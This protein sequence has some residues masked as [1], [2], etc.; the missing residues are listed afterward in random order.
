MKKPYSSREGAKLYK[1]TYKL[2]PSP[3]A[4]THAQ[5][6]RVRS[7]SSARCLSRTTVK[8]AELERKIIFGR[9]LPLSLDHIFFLITHLVVQCW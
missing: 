1:L 2:I 8:G 7:F 9:L 5:H 6:A 4:H 3:M